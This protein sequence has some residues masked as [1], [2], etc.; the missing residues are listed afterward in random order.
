MH[1]RESRRLL[2]LD[3][4]RRFSVLQQLIPLASFDALNGNAV[5]GFIVLRR[6]LIQPLVVVCSA[7]ILMASGPCGDDST[8]SMS[9]APDGLVDT[10]DAGEVRS[11]AGEPRGDAG[12]E[13]ANT[14]CESND[15]CE[16]GERC[17]E[18]QCAGGE[19]ANECQDACARAGRAAYQPCIDEGGTEDDC[20]ARSRRTIA[21]CIEERCER[22]DEPQRCRSNEDCDDGERCVENMCQ[23]DGEDMSCEDACTRRARESYQGCVEGGGSEEDCA[24]RVRRMAE[25]CIADR[26]GDRP[27]PQRCR[28]DEDCER[29][30]ECVENMCQ[31]P[32]IDQRCADRCRANLGAA[33]DRCVADGGSEED[34]RTRVARMYEQC[35]ADNCAD[36]DVDDITRCRSN[37]DCDRGQAC[38]DNQCV[39]ER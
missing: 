24:T 8:R 4:R 5:K 35:I 6:P 14:D 15:D 33:F 38:V 37:D 21:Q 1:T 31:D 23:G 18:N 25:Q 28:S 26:C 27:E 11:D 10:P 16:R 20:R 2:S 9:V 17:V 7:L 19:E 12:G 29:G 13:G 30:Q 39:A 34:C 3:K 32:E 22:D 36:D